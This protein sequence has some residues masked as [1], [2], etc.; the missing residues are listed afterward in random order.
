[1]SEASRLQARK[2]ELLQI[3]AAQRR[4]LRTDLQAVAHEVGR[5]DGWLRLARRVTP[6]VAAGVVVAS[7][8]AGPARVIRLVRGAIVPAVLL[9]QFFSSRR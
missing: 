2:E 1:V 6:L 5:V 7:V 4:D 8:V 3:T 9:R